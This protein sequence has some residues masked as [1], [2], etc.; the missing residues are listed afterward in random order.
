MRKRRL[1]AIA[2]CAALLSL[3][4]AASAGATTWTQVPSGTD[5]TI[6]AIDYRSSTQAWLVTRGG[7]ITGADASGRFR[8][9]ASFPGARFTD[10]AFRP[11]GVVG[12]ATGYGGGIY[13]TDDGGVT[14]ATVAR[15][16]FRRDCAS[17]A[18]DVPDAALHAVAWAGPND[19]WI[20]GG[21]VTT[22]PIVLRTTDA[23]AT[24]SDANDA[25]GSCRVGATGIAITDVW[26]QPGAPDALRFI[27]QA[28][29]GLYASDDGL[30]TPATPKGAT[31]E[32]SPGTDF[33]E[34][35]LAIDPSDV[36]RLW[37]AGQIISRI[38]KPPCG[39]C[40][41][42]SR[43]GG[44]SVSPV[45]LSG[46]LTPETVPGPPL[47]N[48]F[49]DLDYAGGTL[50]AVS[51]DGVHLSLGGL[52]AYRQTPSFGKGW[53]AVD[54]VSATDALVGGANGVLAQTTDAN[55]PDTTPPTATIDGP[56][57]LTVGERGTWTATV[58]DGPGGSG[59][60]P[61]SLWWSGVIP[62]MSGPWGPTATTEFASA[63]VHQLTIGY[64]DRVGNSGTATID[65][66]VAMR[67]TIP[68]GRGQERPPRARDPRNASRPVS[69]RSGGAT[70][71][72]WKQI[73]L[74]RGRNVPVRVSAG[75]AR[76]FVIEVRGAAGSSRP[77]ARTT[78]RLPRA[79]T[80]LVRI[81]LHAKAR[82]GRYRVVVRVYSGRRAVGRPVSLAFK[83]VR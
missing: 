32:S 74:G 46:R 43:D 54:V 20:V 30:A 70:V 67:A 13:R 16:Q 33:G 10:V 73:S 39:A 59:V 38:G 41:V 11:D 68:P 25:G 69:R 45:T 53:S 12:L 57:T 19:A 36:N 35:K 49:L 61:Q 80:K 82:V 4:G 72:L 14:W 47:V 56:R 2:S 66:T 81:P 42:S 7:D 5:Q 15:P 55:D 50:V 3:V 21:T 24:W 37:A 64:L 18:A 22:A 34:P 71:T 60:E 26:V 48:N 58:V 6:A 75:A 17:P 40:L 29:G 27:T 63:G 1:S 76:R 83:A 8:K 28:S 62:H 78:A 79:G 23:G 52:K 9:L 44:A 65:V 51:G 31:V 77:V